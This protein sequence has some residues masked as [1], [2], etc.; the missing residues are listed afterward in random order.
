MLQSSPKGR[1]YDLKRRRELN[2]YKESLVKIITLV[3]VSVKDVSYFSLGSNNNNNR[4]DV[5]ISPST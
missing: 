1:N 2:V 5:A 4:L 3:P